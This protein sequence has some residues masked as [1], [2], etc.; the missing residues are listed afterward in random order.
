MS[1]TKIGISLPQPL[2]ERVDAAARRKRQSRSEF[3]RRSLE[4]A[5]AEETPSHVL[6]EARAL[7]AAIED[8]DLNLAED[9]ITIAAETLPPYKTEE[10]KG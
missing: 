6:A 9:F 7:Y 5:L 10:T 1:V 4:R 3:V 2:L 8:D